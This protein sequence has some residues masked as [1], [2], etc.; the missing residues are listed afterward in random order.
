MDIPD[1]DG[2]SVVDQPFRIRVEVERRRFG[3]EML[4]DRRQLR[5]SVVHAI[6][7]IVIS[8]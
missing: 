4:P 3:S 7:G 6:G 2:R 5:R 1:P 8:A